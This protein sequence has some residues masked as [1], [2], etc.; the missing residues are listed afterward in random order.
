MLGR[1]CELLK[2][3]PGVVLSKF[4]AGEG[5]SLPQN[6]SGKI[7]EGP[8]CVLVQKQSNTYVQWGIPFCAHESRPPRI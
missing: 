2:T 1:Q 7:S 4:G 3:A 8:H 6:E 5:R